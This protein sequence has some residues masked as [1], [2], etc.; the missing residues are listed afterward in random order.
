[1][2]RTTEPSGPAGGVVVGVDGT[3]AS[4]R[5]VRFATAE[6]ARLDDTV[7]AIHVVPDYV[8]VA[9]L[10]VQSEDLTTAGRSVLESTLDRAGPVAG[11]PVAAHVEHGAV[12]P[13]LVHAARRARVV[14]VGSDRRPVSARLLT[15]NVSTGVAARCRAPVVSVPESWDPDRGSGVVVAAV[16]HLRHADALLTESFELAR[17][18]GARLVVLHLWEL[19]FAYDDNLVSDREALADWTRRVQD[20]LVGIVASWRD[21]Y[22]DVEVDVRSEQGQAAHALVAA[23]EVA[24]ELV[25]ARRSHGPAVTHLGSTARTVLLRAH[26]PVR[27]VPADPARAEATREEAGEPV[28]TTG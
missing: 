24:D 16:K 9:G 21:R 6:A 8:P 10:P 5:A 27:V 14:V 19:P 26:C 23:S 11:V 25:L 20:D 2:T 12:V 22:P 17:E 15:G 18:R 3:P 28:R 7:D 13:T 4:V 1:M